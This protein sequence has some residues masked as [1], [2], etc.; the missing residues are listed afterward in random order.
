MGRPGRHRRLAAVAL[1]GL[2]AC[3]GG[4]GAAPRTSGGG[5]GAGTLLPVRIVPTPHSVQVPVDVLPRVLFDGVLAQDSLL[6][7]DTGVFR[8]R[9]DARLP[10]TLLLDHG[11][12]L[13][14]SP[15]AA[16]DAETDYELRIAALTS[17]VDGRLLEATLVVP[18]RT[19]DGTPPRL[20][21]ARPSD[22]ASG[23]SRSGPFAL[24]F[25]DPLDPSSVDGSTV[26]LLGPRGEDHPVAI[27]RSG[28][29]IT[30][31]PRIDLPGNAEFRAVVRGVRDRSGNRLGTS[32][33]TRFRTAIDAAPPQVIATWPATGATVSPRARIE[34]TF[35]EAVVLPGDA[36]ASPQLV[37]GEGEDLALGYEL[38]EDQ[39]TLALVPLEPLPRGVLLAAELGPDHLVYDRSG[40]AS[41]AP[42][43]FSFLAGSDDTPPRLLRA[44]P[45][46]GETRVDPRAVLRLSFDE[47]LDP[48]RLDPLALALAAGG[49][50]LPIAAIAL[51][52]DPR[53]LLVA[54]AAPMPCDATVVLTVRA[55][56]RAIQDVAG[57]VLAPDLVTTF[58]TSTDDVPLALVVWPEPDAVA[59][60]FDATLAILADAPLDPAT[61][62]ST[63]IL[64]LDA[65]QVPVAGT[66]VRER[67]DRVVRFVPATPWTPGAEYTVRIAAGLDGLRKTSGNALASELV[68]SFRA[69]YRADLDPPE[70]EVTVDGIAAPRNAGRVLSSVHLTIDLRA[71]AGTDPSLDLS[72][73]ELTLTGP[74]PLPD[75]DALF[76]RATIGPRS[77]RVQLT[78]D[79]RLA[80]GRYELGARVR[81]LSGNVG[82]AP[83][84]S[85]VVADPTTEVMPFERTQIVWAR[86]DLD[87]DGNGRADFDDDLLQLGL[88]TAGDPLGS[89]ARV[90]AVMRDGVLAAAH[91]L[92]GRRADGAPLGPD[93]VALRFAARQPLGLPSTSIAIGG[94]DPEGNRDRGFGSPSSGTLGRAPFDPRNA[95][96]NENVTLTSPGLGVFPAELFLYEARVHLDVYPAFVTTFARRFLP[97]VPAMG[98]TPA[99]AH[100]LDARVLAIDFDPVTASA[101][102]RA[103][104]DTIWR[105]ADDWAVAVGTILAHEVGHAVG[106]VAP[107]TASTGLF[108]DATLHDD[109]SEPGLV[110]APAIGF[111]AVVAIPFAFRDLD[112]AYLRQRVLLR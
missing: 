39:R 93:S 50:E 88:A 70:L 82:E 54:P 4:G 95:H 108:G 52:D 31:V 41:A 12:E 71:R 66:L 23:V 111:D 72:R 7:P 47:P 61:V 18:F 105:A 106:L 75:A 69:G 10:A 6:D 100:A 87:R 76:A 22:G 99:G 11:K 2:A 28:A 29:T 56:A 8:I 46:D 110:M 81:D 101:A 3:G 16:L 27:T 98:G 26:T 19:V 20:V 60:P 40:N 14:A 33:T 91:R 80:P 97:L 59:V 55:A 30:L 94:F 17:D 35:D 43:R 34:L 73:A 48:R 57:N 79:E 37:T 38:S 85:F 68:Q 103:R 83:V 84:L 74:G 58:A 51:D 44:S 109:Y 21:A 96:V 62:D 9:D 78:P 32:A 24:D 13:V 112:A 15:S 86:F 64:V 49:V 53:T 45:G 107:G 65:A 92:F 25:D 67:G 102:E 63:R 104:W 89:N 36:D 42:L 1:S 5:A 77:L 90:A